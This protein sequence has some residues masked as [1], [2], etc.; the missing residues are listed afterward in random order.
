MRAIIVDDEQLT[1]EY[2]SRLLD[3]CGVEIAGCYTDPVFAVEQIKKLQPDVLFL[4]IE[5]P[6]MSGLELA[7][8]VVAELGETEIVFITAYN[9]YALEA[10]RVNALDYLLK[11]V[12]PEDMQNT[13][14][15]VKKRMGNRAKTRESVVK[16]KVR[17]SF[18][19]NFSITVEETSRPVHWITAK[20]AELL[21]YMLL[22]DGEKE[23]S[24]W[25]LI[26]VLWPDKNPV[27]ADINL[28]STV[29]RLNKTLRD[30]HVGMTVVSSRNGY[31]LE[32]SDI[33]LDVDVFR[34][35]QLVQDRVNIDPDHL[36]T[37]EHLLF[38]Y[39]STILDNFDSVW[40]DSYRDLY[41]QYFL[42]LARQLLIHYEQVQMDPVSMIKLVE[43]IIQYEPYE[44]DYREL[45]LQLY[46]RIGGKKR[47]EEYFLAYTQWLQ[48]ELS[49]E[50]GESLV[51][52]YRELIE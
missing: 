41:H 33:E 26:E 44:D 16:S 32:I 51:Q 49:I 19:G 13:V 15:R 23:I 9:Q 4:D 47:A 25:K 43:R 20:C 22:Q 6:G 52:L 2:I 8:H 45:A 5:M 50:P 21:A 10:F 3:R 12:L 7:E 27:K 24:K 38:Q 34:L 14:N 35:A 37:I 1:G 29:S 36:E 39:D 48:D 28:R 18:F 17:V 11:P 30:D 46:Y 31:H 40:C 42:W